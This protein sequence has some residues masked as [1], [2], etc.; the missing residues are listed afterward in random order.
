M[1]R[2]ANEKYINIKYS[3]YVEFCCNRM[4]S[5]IVMFVEKVNG[6]AMKSP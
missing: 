4:G 2:A 3:N 1:A 6:Q 5:K